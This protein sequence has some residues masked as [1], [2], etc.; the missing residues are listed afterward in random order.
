MWCLACCCCCFFTVPFENV[1]HPPSS[2]AVGSSRCVSEIE[3]CTTPTP[4]NSG[5]F[6]YVASVTPLSP[7]LKKKI[8]PFLICCIGLVVIVTYNLFLNNK[9]PQNAEKKTEK[10]KSTLLLKPRTRIIAA[11]TNLNR[12]ICGTF[13]FKTF[14]LPPTFLSV[15]T[16]SKPYTCVCVCV[17]VCQAS[18]SAYFSRTR[19]LD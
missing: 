5:S 10:I 7:F 2:L 9:K 13:S 4:H 11:K 3:D 1:H 12:L 17:S 6:E 16:A 8:K 14:S 15:K 18:V 19:A